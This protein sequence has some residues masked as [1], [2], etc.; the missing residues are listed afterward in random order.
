MR[1]CLIKHKM[2]GM[3]FFSAFLL[4]CTTA[5]P[6]MEWKDPGY[7]GGPFDNILIVGMSNQETVRRT[8]ENLFVDRLQKVNVQATAS[9]AVMPAEARPSEENIRK[10]ISDIKF[11]SVLVTHLVAVEAED[12]YHPPAYRMA[13]YGGFYGYYRYVGGYVYEPGYYTRHE[14]FRLETNL[15]DVKTEQ[16]VWSMQSETVNPSSEKALFEAKIKTVVDHLKKQNLIV[17]E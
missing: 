1:S 3:L 15:Y 8:F 7:S 17:G 13:P 4:S 16:L 9:F 14:Q 11:D 2:W 12:I 5:K 10:V 6:I